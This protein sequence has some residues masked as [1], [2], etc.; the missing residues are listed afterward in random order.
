RRGASTITQQLAKNLFQTRNDESQGLIRFVPGIRTLIYKVKEWITAFQIERIYNKNEILTLYFNTVPF[1]NNSYGIKAATKRYFN[2]NPD[3]VTLTEAATLVGM[4]KAT[5]TYNPIR[6]PEKT[7]ER[8]NVVLSQL[9]KYK[10]ID[11]K[12]YIELR[13]TDLNLNLSYIEE[14][15]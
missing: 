3:D 12:Q 4:L 5:S 2:K 1:G 10:Y 9:E 7:L 11:S 15:S 6:N 13:K 14:D 8:R